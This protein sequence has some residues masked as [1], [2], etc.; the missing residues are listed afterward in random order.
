MRLYFLLLGYADISVPQAELSAFFE[1]CRAAGLTP[2]NTKRDQKSGDMIC[3]F[4][5]FLA[6][7]VLRLAE[8][9]GLSLSLLR[10][11][12]MPTVLL[13]LVRRPALACGVLAAL[14]L[15]VAAQLVLWDIEITGNETLTDEEVEDSL[16]AAGLVRGA[17]L[18]HLDGDA[19]A[20]AVRQSDARIAYA[21][22]NLSG[23]VAT[24]QIKESEPEPAPAQHTPA[25]LVARRDGVVVMPL[26]FEGECLVAA[27]EAVRAGQLLAS[28]VIDTEN[29]GI[30]ITRAAGQ[31]L[32]RTEEIFTVEVPFDY[33]E[34]SYTGRVFY[35]LD[36]NF[37]AAHGKVFKTTGNMPATCDIIEDEQKFY[38]GAHV[39]PIGFTRTVFREYTWVTAHRTATEALSLANAELA[40]RLSESGTARTLLS[41]TVET[42]VSESGIVLVCTAVFEEDIAAV[43]EFSLAP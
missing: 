13:R 19:I 20:L 36:L 32:A 37:F 33:M 23:T 18:P 17:F 7:R 6:T 38:A 14:V 21:S 12:G 27:G 26:I 25:N 39:L 28:G 41:K 24:V 31:V 35:E 29:N 43:S 15:L 2:K 8:E 10:Q 42:V 1:L 11:G 4:T 16:A 34:K 22:V 3:R 30:R 40:A 5:R 9:Q